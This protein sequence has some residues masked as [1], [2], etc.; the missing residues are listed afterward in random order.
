AVRHVLLAEALERGDLRAAAAHARDLVAPPEGQSEGD[1]QLR[2]ARVLL[3]GG[4]ADARHA[5][6]ARLVERDEFDAEYAARWVQ[7]VFD[8]QALGRHEQALDLLESAQARVDNA[9]MRREL[10]YWRA[11]SASALGRHREAAE[12]Y[13]RSAQ[14]DA[15][16]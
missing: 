10:L 16:G 3:Y 7:V 13:L 5:L 4:E 12:L 2:R 8:L 9:R 6:L 14:L 11:E 15:D 1:W